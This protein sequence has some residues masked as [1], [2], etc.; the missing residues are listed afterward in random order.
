MHKL[1]LIAPVAASLAI[2]AFVARQRCM[3]YARQV[4]A[5]RSSAELS[6]AGRRGEAAR[7]S[8]NRAFDEHREQ[9]LQRLDQEAR[10]FRSFLDRLRHAKDKAEFDQFVT[11][12]RTAP[13]APEAPQQPGA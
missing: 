2:L 1:H 9:M 13:P 10:E 12:R 5:H 7:P 4:C 3:A 11:E 6:H 8:G